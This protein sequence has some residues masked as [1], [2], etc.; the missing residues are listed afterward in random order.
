MS[1][2]YISISSD[3]FHQQLTLSVQHGDRRGP[4]FQDHQEKYKVEVLGGQFSSDAK[5]M[6]NEILRGMIFDF[7]AHGHWLDKAVLS[8]PSTYCYDNIVSV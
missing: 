6:P 8:F 1:S 4:L 7:E 3:F 2:H 5:K